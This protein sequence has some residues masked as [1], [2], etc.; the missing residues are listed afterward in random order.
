MLRRFGRRRVLEQLVL[1]DASYVNS[2]TCNATGTYQRS[3]TA[4]SQ[5]FLRFWISRVG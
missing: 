2:F 4:Y 1:G 5:A 3:D